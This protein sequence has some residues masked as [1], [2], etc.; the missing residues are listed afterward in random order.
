MPGQAQFEY[1]QAAAHPLTELLACP[2]AIADLLN[3]T[4]ESIACET[5]DIVF[6]QG[7]PCRGLYLVIS[8]RLVRKAERFAARLTLGAMQAGDLVELAAALGDGHHTYTL[9]AQTPSSLLILG[10]ETLHRAFHGYPPLRMQLLQELAREVS[11]SYF[12][13]TAARLKEFRRSG[14]SLAHR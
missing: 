4:A 9:A 12:A 11:R 7:D 13:C 2:P 14:G 3:A 5:G 10:I 1:A 6:R 8:G